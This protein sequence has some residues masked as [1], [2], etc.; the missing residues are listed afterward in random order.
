MYSYN[1]HYYN[2]T[3]Y[4]VIL[5]PLSLL[6]W[7]ISHALRQVQEFIYVLYPPEAVSFSHFS[8]H[9]HTTKIKD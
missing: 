7:N 4:Y 5:L 3:L 1:V 6:S 2:L 8:A 9:T